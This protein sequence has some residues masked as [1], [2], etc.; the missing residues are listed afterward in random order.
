VKKVPDTQRALVL[1]GGGSLG[2][3]EAGAY[4]A[5]YERITSTDRQNGEKGR[6]FLN[7]VAG[8]SIGAINAAIIVSYVVENNTWDGSAE[9][10]NEF[11]DYLSKESS[12]DHIPGFTDWWD[13]FHNNFHSGIASGEAAR[14]YY[15]AK[16]FSIIGVPTV[17]SPLVPLLDTRFFDLQKIWYRFDSGPLKRSLERFAKFPIATSFDEKSSLPQPRLLLVSVDVAEGAAVTFDSYETEDG[18][19]KSEYGKFVIQKGKEL[20]NKHIVRYNDGITSEHVIA[21]ASVPINYS[22]TALEV[23]SYNDNT[24]KY[25]KNIRYFWDGGIMHNT[26]LTQ[27]VRLHR[28]YWLKVKG[29]KDN[30]PRI[31]IGIINVHP[32]RQDLIPWDHDGVINRNNDIT[33][34]DRTEREQQALL[35]ASDYVDLARKLIKIAKDHGAKDDTINN[36]LN[37]N[38]LNHG[39]AIKPRK[40]S[41]ILVGQFEIGRVIRVNRKNDE[42]TISDKTFD[43]SQKTIT[44]LRESGYNNTMDLS[45]VEFG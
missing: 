1:Q 27:L 25:E 30:V 15:S 33:F 3:Y 40:Y 13:Y 14:R 11:W 16:E 32:V 21:S 2:A 23:E 34:S 29:L 35:L 17:F 18:S 8:T 22:Y 9:R 39:L 19:R 38:T 7:I 28:L 45:D 37:S 41:D 20:G 6:P 4:Q 5:L 10:L 36:L 31:N 44:E 26:P 12:L 24:A 43:F 42:H